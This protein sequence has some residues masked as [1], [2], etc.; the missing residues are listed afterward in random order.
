[1]VGG[2]VLQ[3]YG[4]PS[5]LVIDLKEKVSLAT[6]LP[7][8]EQILLFRDCELSNQNTLESSGVGRSATVHLAMATSS[9]TSPL[10]QALSSVNATLSIT[11]LQLNLGLMQLVGSG[12]ATHPHPPSL[13]LP[14]HTL[15]IAHLYDVP[16]V[17]MRAFVGFLYSGSLDLPTGT[18][19]GEPPLLP[20]E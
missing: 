8:I 19:P 9:S 17:G 10:P 6:G 16:S 5:E 4:R 20:R 12:V 14:L 2:D 18:V 15:H 7:V 3:C 1:M 11:H 13:H